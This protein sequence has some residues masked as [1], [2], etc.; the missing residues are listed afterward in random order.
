V[1]SDEKT[2]LLVQP[3]GAR[4]HRWDPVFQ[5][6]I[7]DEIAAHTSKALAESDHLP[8][9]ILW[10][11]NLLTT[12]FSRDSKLETRF[13]RYVDA[14]NVPVVTGLVRS[15]KDSGPGRYRNSIVWW[16]PQ[17][18]LRDAIDKVRAM[19]LVESDRDFPGRSL[20]TWLVGGAATGTHVAES[21]LARTLAG[22][23]SLSPALCFEVL[24]PRIVAERR[25]DES[26][27]IVNLADDSWVPGEIADRQLIAAAAFRA[28]EQRLTLVRVS[29][30]GLSGVVDPFGREIA[31]LPPDVLAHHLVRVS[32]M[33]RPSAVERMSMLALAALAGL[34]GYVGATQIGQRNRATKPLD[35][36]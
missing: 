18:G 26:F 10:P 34:A 36:R 8:D 5:S 30:G 11:E 12:P 32:A 1:A 31:S 23:F 21:D 6:V 2:L 20:M 27:A 33:P 24:F 25:S 16:A 19:P 3:S 35:D 9:A 13:R 29:H 28:I 4:A 15:T 22:E 17:T 14:W 7:L